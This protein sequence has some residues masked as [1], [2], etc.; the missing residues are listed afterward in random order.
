MPNLADRIEA[1]RIV[2]SSKE[3]PP[4][5]QG[6]ATIRRN[7][8]VSGATGQTARLIK[9]FPA[10]DPQP[11]T[12]L[13]RLKAAHKTGTAIVDR[14]EEYTA[15]AAKDKNLSLEGRRDSVLHSILH[16]LI[17]EA[18]KARRLI[19][20]AKAEVAE[21]KSKLVI[22]APS[23][24]DAAAAIRRQE[25]RSLL[26]EM[27]AAKQA[28]YFA[29]HKKLPAEVVDAVLEMPA[30]FC[31]V[32]PERQEW[33][34]Q[35]VLAAQYGPELAEITQIEEA[36]SAAESTV[37]IGRD[38]LRLEVGGLSVDD[39]NTL[40]ATIE[41]KQPKVP[42]LRK[43]KD[44]GGAEVVRVIT[45]EKGNHTPQ[46]ATPEQIAAGSFFENYDAYVAATTP[47]AS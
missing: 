39:F 7:G 17:P 29:R 25:I 15:T 2:A 16:E 5:R 27:P 33:L 38:E 32:A 47:T 8:S 6:R 40:A 36:I 26:N 14:A 22:A 37:E 18:H 23:G 24:G 19:N 4:L 28:E 11:N 31:G 30:E 34:R 9:R 44:A 1:A 35:S 41:A 13:A 10:V 12:T 45:P 21:R 43:F 20:K 3:E 46:I 42:W